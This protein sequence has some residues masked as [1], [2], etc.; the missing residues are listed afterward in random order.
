[1]YAFQQYVSLSQDYNSKLEMLYS[2][3]PQLN[4]IKNLSIYNM[5]NDELSEMLGRFHGGYKRSGDMNE[6]YTLLYK[7]QLCKKKILDPVLDAS[8]IKHNSISYIS[9]YITL[10]ND[11]S[12]N[13]ILNELNLNYQ[14]QVYYLN[15]INKNYPL[16]NQ[17]SER[18]NSITE[19]F[20]K[21]TQLNI[22]KYVASLEID[23]EQRNS[24][25]LQRD[26]DINTEADKIFNFYEP[27]HH[28]NS[29]IHREVSQLQ[30][31]DIKNNSLEL[32][33]YD[34]FFSFINKMYL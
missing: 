17:I 22:N 21:I 16:I 32:K 13:K 23:E 33:E 8:Q 29:K 30:L 11:K 9:K 28:L 7:T 10:L 27:I 18:H 31:L 6:S 25:I 5:K 19:N 24:L 15:K 1:M 20:E 26:Q 12:L 4:L 3:C 14:K 34:E 2:L